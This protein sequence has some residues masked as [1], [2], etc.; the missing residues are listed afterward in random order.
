[1][2]ENDPKGENSH[3]NWVIAQNIRR[4]LDCML[5]SFQA[6]SAG[7]DTGSDVLR[8][9]GGVKV[10]MVRDQKPCDLASH[11]QVTLFHATCAELAV[12]PTGPGWGR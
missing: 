6:A 7:W 11:Q 3:K 8:G 10:T 12:L 1:M 2:V 4:A 9:A 5:G